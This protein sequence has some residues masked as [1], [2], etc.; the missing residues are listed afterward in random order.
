[1][2]LLRD[3]PRDGQA[4]PRAPCLR[5][6]ERIEDLRLGSRREARSV[7]AHFDDDLAPSCLDANL[8]W[9]GPVRRRLDCVL[10]EVVER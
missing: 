2:V 9:I 5:R 4:E 1:M 6:H 3:A 8:D 7:V 10:K